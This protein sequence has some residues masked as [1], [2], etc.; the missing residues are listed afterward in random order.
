MDA[1][2]SLVM[3]MEDSDIVIDLWECNKNGQDRFGIFWDK[4][5]EFLTSC[6]SVYE[7]RCGT[8]L[9]M[10]KAV[11]VRDL[12]EQVTKLCPAGI[13]IPSESWVRFNFYPHNPRA[14][15]A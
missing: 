11:S 3:A 1:R 9:F 2:V 8:I 10:T 14:K 4:C 13:P 15:V 12:I 7:R 5:N 6:T